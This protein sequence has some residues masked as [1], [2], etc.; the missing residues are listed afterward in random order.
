MAKVIHHFHDFRFCHFI[1]DAQCVVKKQHVIHGCP[2]EMTLQSDKDIDNESDAGDSDSSSSNDGSYA[3]LGNEPG[4][5]ST[6]GTVGS[7]TFLG[8]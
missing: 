7:Y 5:V 4:T 2:V 1:P 8:N 6:V 3:F